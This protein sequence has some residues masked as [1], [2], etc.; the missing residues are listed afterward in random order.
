[1]LPF[2]TLTLLPCMDPDPSSLRTLRRSLSMTCAWCPRRGVYV[3]LR[4]IKVLG[5]TARR[6]RMAFLARMANRLL[7]QR[8][9]ARLDKM[10]TA[11]FG[12]IPDRPMEIPED[13]ALLET[14]A[15]LERMADP[16]NGAGTG[17]PLCWM[18]L[19]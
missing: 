11:A 19:P 8:K 6:V 3:C 7:G 15:P 1:M 18:P 10:G 12:E 9:A 2:S 17:S 5:M 4:H 14:P 16:A 13:A